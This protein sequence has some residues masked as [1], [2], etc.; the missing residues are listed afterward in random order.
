MTTIKRKIDKIKI[1]ESDSP[2][3][4]ALDKGVRCMHCT[5]RYYLVEK[6]GDVNN[7]FCTYCGGL[8]PLRTIRHSRGLT[9]PSIQ[10]TTAIIQAKPENTG[11]HRQ[12]KP[13]N[14]KKNPLE[15]QLINQGL[16]VLSSDY[17]EY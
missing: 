16:T 12:P 3:L 7:L 14:K 6:K 11:F 13:I 4:A 1:L 15:E 17:V 2:S 8:T 5:E 9:A 10:Q